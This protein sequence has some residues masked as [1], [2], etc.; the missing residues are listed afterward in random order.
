MTA[1]PKTYELTHLDLFSGI[2]GFALMPNRMNLPERLA[3]LLEQAEV[4][5]LQ[6]FCEVVYVLKLNKRVGYLGNYPTC[7]RLDDE[8]VRSEATCGRSFLLR[9]VC[10]RKNKGAPFV[11]QHGIVTCNHVDQS[12]CRRASLGDLSPSINS[13]LMGHSP[14][15]LCDIAVPDM[16]LR[17]IWQLISGFLRWLIVL[18]FHLFF[19]SEH[20]L[21]SSYVAF[22]ARPDKNTTK[23]NSFG[24]IFWNRWLCFGGPMGRF[25]N[26]GF[27]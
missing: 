10:V 15:V 14:K 5:I 24:L 17:T 11:V 25:P 21:V 22:Y 1:A 2:G 23:T 9:L 18:T 12:T 27:L 3:C 20:E 7:F 8:H 6:A 4:Q 13:A 16:S 26:G 19:Q